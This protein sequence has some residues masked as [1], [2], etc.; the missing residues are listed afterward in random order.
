MQ[1]GRFYIKDVIGV[2][3]DALMC[4]GMTVWAYG[5]LR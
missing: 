4:L 5:L 2:D 3:W 1:W